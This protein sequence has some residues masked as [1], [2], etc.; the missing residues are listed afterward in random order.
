MA[1]VLFVASRPISSPPI[2]LDCPQT[3]PKLLL[4]ALSQLAIARFFDGPA[5]QPVQPP[6]V[7]QLP[8]VDAEDDIYLVDPNLI[9]KDKKTGNVIPLVG[10][11]VSAHVNHT[12]AEVVLSVRFENSERENPIEAIMH[13]ADEGMIVHAFDVSVGDSIVQGVCM[14]REEAFAKYDDAISSGHAAFLGEKKTKRQTFDISAGNLAPGMVCVINVRY[15]IKL[16]AVGDEFIFGLPVTR[17]VPLPAGAGAPKDSDNE[18]NSKLRAQVPAGLNVNVAVSQP[19]RIVNLVCDSHMA[20]VE[21][22]DVTGRVSLSQNGIEAKRFEV[23]IGI[24]D[25]NQSSCITEAVV[26]EKLAD[27]DHLPVVVGA[28]PRVESEQEAPFDFGPQPGMAHGHGMFGSASAQSGLATKFKKYAVAL[29]MVPKIQADVDILSEIIFL[30]DCSGSMAGGRMRRAKSALALFLRALPASCR[31]NIFAFGDRYEK[32]FEFPLQY[33]EQSL[34]RALRWVD[35][36]DA[37]LGGTNLLA[38]FEELLATPISAGWTTRQV[39]LLTD[40]DVKNKADVLS[41]IRGN[42]GDSTRI[43]AFGIGNEV[44][45]ALMK[46]IARYGRGKAE[47]VESTTPLEAP[48]M[49]QVTRALQPALENF[50][51]EW[52]ALRPAP[53]A[54]SPNVPPVFDGERFD[55]F[56]FIEAPVD[57]ISGAVIQNLHEIKIKA[58]CSQQQNFEFPCVIDLNA[59]DMEMAVQR[60]AAHAEIDAMEKSANREGYKQSIITL[61]TRYHLASKYTSFVAVHVANQAATGHM[62]SIDADEAIHNA[63]AAAADDSIGS[64]VENFLRDSSKFISNK[65]ESLRADVNAAAAEPV[66]ELRKQRS[67]SNAPYGGAVGGRG[68][69][70]HAFES[71][72]DEEAE[73][74]IA[75]DLDGIVSKHKRGNY[76]LDEMLSTQSLAQDDDI[77]EYAM[78]RSAAE[79]KESASPRA[80]Q[81]QSTTS[82]LLESL[83][84]MGSALVTKVESMVDALDEPAPAFRD[85]Y[86]ASAAAPKPM[87]AKAS[88]TT[89]SARGGATAAPARPITEERSRKSESVM[90]KKDKDASSSP[91]KSRKS[92]VKKE[93]EAPRTL[94]DFA[95]TL[96]DAPAPPPPAPCSGPSPIAMPAPASSPSAS[97]FSL[98]SPPPPGAPPQNA[99]V[100]SFSDAP[101]LPKASSAMDIVTLGQASGGFGLDASLA[102][103]IGLTLAHILDLLPASLSGHP[104]IWATALAITALEKLFSASKDE[105]SL[106]YTKGRRYISKQITS[107]GLSTTVDEVLA[108]A[109]TAF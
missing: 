5:A 29:S 2:A 6:P 78:V 56:A 85:S 90:K 32:M 93:E 52:G 14:E 61:A 106:I 102:G 94:A 66:G 73:Y 18:H 24:A 63:K 44:S 45:Q 100:S 17:T 48:V 89:M 34:D 72:E 101:V 59:S 98:P 30:M 109:A 25:P 20:E 80:S 35:E 67:T 23:R 51:I 43:F 88:P 60:L 77:P 36:R 83:S 97:S 37:K 84:S 86:T 31:F 39:F 92:S 4:L 33:N 16:D 91:A 46:G 82:R 57:P 68:E 8:P 49:R 3:D 27:S 74:D 54:L 76:N 71:S 15:T 69:S 41:H 105:W 10:L 21:K 19:Q 50:E 79:E 62:V 13:L 108:A 22:F 107:L 95:A 58:S 40:G 28:Q 53:T 12:T 9:V 104:D 42:I 99:P 96:S 55:Y 38:P 7:A 47:F 64:R 70:F 26:D 11:K 81:Q 87:L 103:R 1:I 75:D 65:F